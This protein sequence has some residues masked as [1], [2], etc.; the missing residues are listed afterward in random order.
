MELCDRI[1]PPVA[2]SEKE[3]LSGFLDF[4]R[5]TM[6]CKLDGLSDE[7]VRRPHEPSGLTLL[8]IVKHLADVERSWFRDV[9]RGEDFSERWND[10]DP[11]RYWR[12]EPGE[13]TADILAFYNTEVEQARQIVAAAEMSDVAKAELPPKLAGLQL[14]WIVTH[15]IEETGRHCGHADLIRE[16]IDGRTGE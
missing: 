14:R 11:E 6:L 8:G 9:F 4:L 10:P 2:G 7:E 12:I 13:T 3:V 15:M 1:D 5:A 16:A